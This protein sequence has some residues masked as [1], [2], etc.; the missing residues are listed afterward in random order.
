MQVALK[1]YMTQMVAEVEIQDFCQNISIFLVNDK[2]CSIEVM[3]VSVLDSMI[4][5]SSCEA[6][7][8]RHRCV[9]SLVLVNGL[10]WH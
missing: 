2:T 9:L 5:S 8:S 3:P 1:V 7:N 4:G 10:L 6:A